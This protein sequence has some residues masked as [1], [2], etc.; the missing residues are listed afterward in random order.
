MASDSVFMGRRDKAY[1]ERKPVPRQEFID[2]LVATLDEIQT[3]LLNRARQ[4]QQ[5]NT[6]TITSKEEF[7]EFF[8]GDGGFALAHWNGDAAIEAQI[9]QDLAVTIRC[10]PFEN[11][12]PGKCI[13]TGEPSKQKVI[14]AKAY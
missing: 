10:I 4:F 7:Y 6:V 11:D 8:K 1:K 3:G 2:N 14:F 9:K 12:G 5:D 13:F